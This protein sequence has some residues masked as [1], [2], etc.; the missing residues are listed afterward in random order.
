L[1][2]NRVVGVVGVDFNMEEIITFMNTAS[3]LDDGYLSLISP[4]GLFVSHRN[5]DLVMQSYKNTWLG[6]HSSSIDAILANGGSFST[7]AY[8]DV[9]NTN[10]S[11]LAKGVTVGDTGKYWA[12]SAFV[13]MSTVNAAATTLVWL[14]IGIGAALIVTVGLVVLLLIS[15][16]LRDLPAMTTL[17]ERIAKGD[18]SFDNFCPDTSAT[19]NE[20]TLLGRSFAG[21][22]NSIKAQSDIM[23]TISGGDY[24]VAIPTRCEADVMNKSINEMIDQTNSVMSEINNISTQV[25]VST[26]EVAETASRIASGASQMAEGAKSL[27]EG[28]MKQTKYMDELSNS[29]VEI[30]E[31]TKVN[32]GMTDQAAKLADTIVNKAEKGSHHMDD[33]VTAVNGINEASKA[34]SMIMETINGIAGQTNLLSLNAAIEAARAGEHGK[35]FAV[36]AEEVRKLAV[37]SSAA[38]EETS[39]IIRVSMEQSE[40]GARVADEM[41]ASLKEIVAGIDESSRLIMEIAKASEHQLVS[42]SKINTNI[43][44][45]SDIIKNNNAVAE[46]NAVTSRE[47]AAAAEKSAAS[48]EEMSSQADLLKELIT[49]FKLKKAT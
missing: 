21:I 25:S 19:K 5:A 13:P 14:I 49:Q 26:K 27:A 39:S 4:D 37:Q 40:L 41:A 24:S 38:V 46:E 45:V 30:A 23:A 22:S 36:V 29:V 16:S 11:L 20:I 17:A 43:D 2:G 28:V 44:Q 9:T 32:A 35:G 7:V 33:M 18:I 48:S 1:E 47:S 3:I 6:N 8:S 12:V 10:M 31:K 34:V 15:R 42:I